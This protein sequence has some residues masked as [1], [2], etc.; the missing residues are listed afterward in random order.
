LIQQSFLEKKKSK[1]S[2]ELVSERSSHI[3]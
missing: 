2:D 3:W 1:F